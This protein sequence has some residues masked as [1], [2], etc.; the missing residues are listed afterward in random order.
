MKTFIK[1]FVIFV[2]ILVSTF[3]HNSFELPGKKNHVREMTNSEQTKLDNEIMTTMT[4][5]FVA[6][7]VCEVKQI[8]SLKS[9]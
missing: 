2:E 5:M 3:F 4:D 9:G 6:S 8:N 7:N 1:T